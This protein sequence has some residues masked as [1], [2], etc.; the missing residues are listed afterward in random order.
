MGTWEAP[1]GISGW[2]NCSRPSLILLL[3]RLA[4]SREYGRIQGVGW[5][6]KGG[7]LSFSSPLI[8]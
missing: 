6:W 2:T 7:H 4:L 5:V 1:K 8:F 3:K